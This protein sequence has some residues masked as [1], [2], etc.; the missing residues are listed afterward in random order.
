MPRKLKKYKYI[1]QGPAPDLGPTEFR[2]SWE[3]NYAR[4]LNHLG[5]KWVYEPQRFWLSNSM[6]YL[7]DFRLDSDNPWDA[8]WIEIKGLWARHDKSRLRL[9]IS[10]YPKEKIKVI[11]SSAY[12]KLAKQ[13]R[14]IIPNWEGPKSRKKK[15]GNV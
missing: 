8:K 4:I 2:S 15:D 7:P 13:Y 9:F 6:S 3:R 1:K 5:I 11:S 14:D 10:M 12:K